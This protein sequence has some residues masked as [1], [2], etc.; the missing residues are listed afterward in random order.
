MFCVSAVPVG[1]VA[2]SE[3]SQLLSSGTSLS[4]GKGLSSLLVSGLVTQERLHAGS[5]CR[6]CS[7]RTLC[8][9][10]E[11]SHPLIIVLIS[12]IAIATGLNLNCVCNFNIYFFTITSIML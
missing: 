1:R 4:A 3:R 9:D 11:V 7:E 2:C 8:D 5:A 10:S 12:N 6:F